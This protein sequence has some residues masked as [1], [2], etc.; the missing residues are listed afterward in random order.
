M[1][2]FWN[3]EKISGYRKLKAIYCIAGRH[4]SATMGIEVDI[5]SKERIQ[6][7]SRCF[8]CKRKIS[9]TVND[10]SNKTE[11]LSLLFKDREEFRL[12]QVKC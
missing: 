2:I 1:L 3:C 4:F 11:R 7:V 12:E 8:K 5:V 9:K 10:N 6:K